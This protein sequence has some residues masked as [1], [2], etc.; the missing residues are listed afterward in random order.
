MTDTNALHDEVAALTLKVARPV[1]WHDRTKAWPKEF[2]GATCFFLKF[3]G[4]LIG[5]TA[6]HVVGAYESALAKNSN[7][8]CQLRNS[9]IFDLTAAIIDRDAIRDLATFRVSAALV[10]HI[11]AIAIDCRNAWPPPEPRREGS[12]S[13]CG[14]P[15][16]MRVSRVDRTAEIRA[17]GALATI[18]DVTSNEILITYD[19]TIAKVPGWAPFRPP[20]GFNLSGCSGGPVLLHVM[21]N[22]LHRWFPVALISS[23]PNDHG[24]QGLAAEFDLI[25]LKRINSIL[26]DGSISRCT[27]AESGWLPNAPK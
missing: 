18:E 26:P 17:W 23:G 1:I 10:S 24:K 27:A 16:S 14:F 15:E 3:E 20:V 12:L 19:P 25:R 7:T 5:I 4:G 21:K 13:L 8:V 22:G 11:E 2:G 9:P 6:D